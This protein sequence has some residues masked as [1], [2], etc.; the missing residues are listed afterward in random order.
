VSAQDID[1]NEEL[2]RIRHALHEARNILSDP[3]APRHERWHGDA[4]LPNLTRVELIDLLRVVGRAFDNID[5]KIRLSG[6]HP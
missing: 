1:P 2:A 4:F 5:D 6:E 3:D